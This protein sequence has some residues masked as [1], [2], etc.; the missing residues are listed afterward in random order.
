MSIKNIIAERVFL[1]F[2]DAFT[3]KKVKHYLSFLN[4][5]QWWSKEQLLDYQ[6]A[7]LRKLI[8]HSVA[9]V[10]YYKNLFNEL[11]LK[12][13]DID[14]K[15]DL[16]KLPILTKTDIKKLGISHFTS[17]A[18][19]KCKL[20]KISSSG[21]TGEPLQYY[22]T[23]DA[24]SFN[25]AAGLRGWSWMG[26]RL[27][28][29]YVKL[30]QNLRS[31]SLKRLQ[32]FVSNNLYLATDIL[33]DSNFDRILSKIEKFK[34]KI[35]RC[36]P[37]P[38][39]FL[40][41]YK[42]NHKE[43]KWKPLAITTTGN[44]LFPET[45]N[46]IEEAFGCKIFDSYSCEGNPNVFECPTHDGYHSSMEYGISEVI[47]ENNDNINDG[48]GKLISTDLQ[49]FAHP[50]IR[51]DTQ[52][53]I[54]VSSESCSCGRKLLKIREILGRHNDILETP[55]GKFIQHHFNGFFTQ[56]NIHLNKSI[57]QF[58]VIKLKSNVRFDFI[59]NKNFNDSIEDYIVQHWEE[60]FKLPVSIKLVK[61]MDYTKTGKR[62]YIINEFE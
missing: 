54:E 36:Y 5:S 23:K 37:D 1:P 60:R 62:R 51:Y 19:L 55:N 29:K 31:S 14:S 34:P 2:G 18:F 3:G 38:L 46:E 22:I 27:G 58:Q 53:L 21:S 6:N 25:I 56:K 50:F 28:D 26:F 11:G 4:E 43:F 10:P 47:D 45:R 35:I 16:I 48:V 52:D 39:L 30:S 15:G 20:I 17:N 24:Y 33:N 12:P 41:R 57:E 40:A 8:E 13:N 61:E 7:Q 9:T 32:D 49:N 59:V 42:K 44:M